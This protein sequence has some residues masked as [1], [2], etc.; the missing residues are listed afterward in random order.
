[1]N[2]S[3]G[4][5]G[6]HWRH[7]ND[8]PIDPLDGDTQFAITIHSEWIIWRS[9]GAIYPM[10]IVNIDENGD[11]G[12]SSTT[13]AQIAM[14]VIHWCHCD[15]GTNDDNGVKVHHDGCHGTNGDNGTDGDNGTNGDNGAQFHHDGCYG[16]NGNGNNGVIAAAVMKFGTI[17]AIDVIGAIVSIGTI[18]AKLAPLSPLVS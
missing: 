10:S 14:M 17:V 5:I 1:M 13:M 12:D 4:A 16:T 11:N 6:D 18:V 9:N 15:N 7:L 2:E 3:F 8:Q